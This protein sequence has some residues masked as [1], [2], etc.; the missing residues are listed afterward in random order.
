MLERVFLN[1]S[2]IQYLHHLG[3]IQ[4]IEDLFGKAYIPMEVV[5]ELRKGKEE[6]IELPELEG[7]DFIEIVEAKATS[8]TKLVRDLGKGETAV[9]LLGI[10]SPNSLVVLDDYLARKVARELG[11]K[12]T[13]TAGIL[14]KAKER[15]FIKTVKP[16]LERLEEIGFYLAPEHK[17]LILKK[18]GE[19]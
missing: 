2:V 1:T 13:G 15:G 11:I 16:Y 10:E 17:S 3:L 4:I 18:A 6:G 9:I 7:I 14:I 8:L 12:V 5:E 19:D